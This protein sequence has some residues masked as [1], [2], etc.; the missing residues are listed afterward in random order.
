MLHLYDRETSGN[1]YKVRLLLAFL[2]IPYDR[3]FV[4]LQNGKNQ[5]DLSYFELNPRGQIPTLMDGA[6]TLWGSTAALCYVASK[7][8]ASR[9]WLPREPLQ[10]AEVMQWLELAQNE[11]QSGLFMARA[12]TSFGYPGNLDEAKAK[13]TTAL[14][15]L[16]WRLAKNSWLVGSTPTIAD[17]ACFPY[18]ALANEGRVDVSP[19]PGISAWLYSVKSIPNFVPMPGL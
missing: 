17:I 3:T 10:F 12:I 9:T 18:V 15:T 2:R 11:I 4:P 8:D 6:S 19:Y 14:Q 5:V 13:A 1:S 7:Y 16:E